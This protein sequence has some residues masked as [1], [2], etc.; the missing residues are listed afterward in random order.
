MPGGGFR[1]AT[2]GASLT[3]YSYGSESTTG[4]RSK[5]PG[6]GGE[7]ACHSRLRDRHGLAGA[8]SRQN[9][10][11]MTKLIRKISSEPPSRNDEIDDQTLSACR[12]S[13][14]SNTRRGM[15][16]SPTANSGRNV[17]LKK[18]NMVQ[19]WILP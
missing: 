6:G 8:G 19:K 12:L 13:A 7:G 9:S 1:S 5:L 18:M 14:Y 4:T 11:D 16:M 10:V 3:P 2:G 17:E 15:P